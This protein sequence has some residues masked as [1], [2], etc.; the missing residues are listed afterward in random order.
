MIEVLSFC[1]HLLAVKSL[2]VDFYKAEYEACVARYS[3]EKPKVR[4]KERKLSTKRSSLAQKKVD[5]V[6]SLLRELRKDRK[7]RQPPPS[8]T[9]RRLKLLSSVLG[10]DIAVKAIIKNQKNVK[11]VARI[12]Y[13]TLK[14]R[15]W[16]TNSQTSSIIGDFYIPRGL[17]E[18]KNGTFVLKLVS[19]WHNINIKFIPRGKFY[20]IMF[21][22]L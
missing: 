4:R 11:Y 7:N 1:A 12:K 13:G 5:S 19:K 3:D 17:Y 14:F 9:L 8:T 6:N 16:I 10:D 21:K 22:K 20:Q 2:G 15:L 18:H